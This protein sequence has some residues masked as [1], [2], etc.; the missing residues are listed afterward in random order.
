LYALLV[1]LRKAA[2]SVAV[3][4]R[5]DPRDHLWMWLVGVRR[6]I[7]FP[8]R[9]TMGTLNEP[10]DRRDRKQHKVQDWQQ[11]AG[12]LGFPETV[13]PALPGL[14]EEYGRDGVRAVLASVSEEVPVVTLHA[15]ARIAV[16]RWEEDRFAALVAAL[17][18]RY[19]FHLVLVPDPDGYGRGLAKFADTVIEKLTLSDLVHLLARSTLFLG[20]DSGPGH[21]AAACGTATAVVFG[22]TDP[23]WFRPWGAENR[24]LVFIRDLCPYRPC[25][26]Y[27]RF[28]EAVCM[29]GLK[30]PT[31]IGDLFPW[32]EAARLL[33]HH[34]PDHVV[35]TP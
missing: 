8:T 28:A 7:G 32:L 13:E 15:G 31:V 17:R 3:S 34:G 33:P 35:P 26:D 11:V 14:A 12:V 10:L 4:V 27:C 21:I 18:Q 20:N 2:F 22:P 19:R 9:F 1:L 23:D 29:T 6:R 25:F 5:N 30:V 16:R 24:H